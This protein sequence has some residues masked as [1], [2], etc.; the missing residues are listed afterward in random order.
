MLIEIRHPNTA[1]VMISNVNFLSLRNLSEKM[2]VNI[3]KE[4]AKIVLKVIFP[5]FCL[6]NTYSFFAGRI[7]RFSWK[8]LTIKEDP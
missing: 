7:L 2:V 6:L 8:T 4:L 5:L 1:M 3:F